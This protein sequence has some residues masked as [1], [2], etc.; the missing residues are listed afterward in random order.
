MVASLIG[1]STTSQLAHPKEYAYL[2]PFVKQDV[3]WGSDEWFS[4]ITH[5]NDEHLCELSLDWGVLKET[6]PG[7]N[8]IWG[9]NKQKY[10]SVGNSKL[11]LDS[12]GGRH[13]AII[14]L[15]KEING[16]AYTFSMFKDVVKWHEIVSWAD[17]KNGESENVHHQNSFDG[18]RALINRIF[19]KSW[20]KLTPAQRTAVIEKSKLS[21]LSDK[22]KA[23]MIAATGIAARATLA[24][25]IT[26]SGF[27]FYTTMSSVIAATANV[28][29]VTLPFVVYTT[30]SSTVAVLTGPLGWALLAAGSAGVGLYAMSP[31]EAR[32]TRMVISLHILKVKALNDSVK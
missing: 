32:V 15:Q 17:K 14:L 3:R 13:K 21:T 9:E 12:L 29:G 11:A 26:M 1:C 27:S 30:A 18:E 19:E 20:D 23:V 28:V 8:V 2:A 10:I 25:A 6:S 7:I 31:D 16:A 4:F 22:D 5:L 24:T